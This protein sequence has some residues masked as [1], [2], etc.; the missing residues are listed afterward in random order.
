M[1]EKYVDD[2]DDTNKN[3][4]KWKKN[5]IRKIVETQKIGCIC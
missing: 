3:I 2:I 5:R 4:I 1:R